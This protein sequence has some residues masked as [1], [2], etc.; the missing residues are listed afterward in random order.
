MYPPRRAWRGGGELCEQQILRAYGVGIDCHSRFIAVCVL[1]REGD[2]VRRFE[3]EFGVSWRELLDACS[4]A[5]GKAGCTPGTLRYCIESTGTYHMPVLRAWMGEPSV[6]N[7][8]LAGPTRRKTDVLDARLLAHHSITGMWPASYVPDDNVAQLRVLWAARGEAARM[9]TRCTNRINN[10]ILRWGHTVAAETPIR[11]GAGMAIVEGLVAG[12]AYCG[13]FVSPLGLPVAVR[14]VVGALVK[15]A[16]SWADRERAARAEALAFVRSQAWICGPGGRLP[17]A[18][19]LHLLHTVP[20]VGDVTAVNWLSEV[21][22]PGRFRTSEQVAAFAGCDP[23]LKVS[24]GKVTEYVKRKGNVRL[25]RALL[26]AASS[27]LRDTDS[28]LSQWGQSIAGRHRKG[29]YKKAV[30]AVARR[31]AVALWHVHR[32]GEPFDLSLYHF[33][34][35]PRVKD[36]PASAI[37]LKPGQAACLPKG[38]HTAQDVCNAYFGGQLGGVRGVGEGTMRAI[39]EWAKRNRLIEPTNDNHDK[40]RRKD[41]AGLVP[42]RRGG[43][44]EAKGGQDGGG[45]RKVP[46]EPVRKDQ[47]W[48]GPGRQ[49]GRQPGARRYA[50]GR[51]RGDAGGGD[52]GVHEPRHG[53]E[54]PHVGRQ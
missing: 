33:G 25:H 52:V 31:V 7:P 28:R 15:D 13:G 39:H 18:R 26:F 17:G 40:E 12:E 24:A 42:A 11:S 41:R 6:V 44:Q 4:W 38:L 47:N 43:G 54:P 51:G 37:G 53:R 27:V 48:S 19:V 50:R 34:R 32:L 36:A 35:N 5:S 29:G 2:S 16:R 10:I 20:G 21:G 3:K 14:P 30:G 22:D 45:G 49:V 23:S 46:R 9:L 1:R 8:L